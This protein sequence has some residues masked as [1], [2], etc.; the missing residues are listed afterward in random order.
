MSPKQT[1]NAFSVP[2]EH[3]QKKGKTGLKKPLNHSLSHCLSIGHFEITSAATQFKATLSAKSSFWRSVFTHIES[4]TVHIKYF[5][6]RLALKKRLKGFG[7]NLFY[8]GTLA[9]SEGYMYFCGALRDGFIS[10]S[11]HRQLL[12]KHTME[13]HSH[14]QQS[15]QL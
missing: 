3:I 2:T 15:L 6:L 10:S 4:R 11:T 14:F 12:W 5:A 9:I 13:D 8:V 1:E 7:N